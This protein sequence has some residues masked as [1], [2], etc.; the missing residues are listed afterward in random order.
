[1]TSFNPFVNWGA[2]PK[3]SAD[4]QF[5]FKFFEK[6]ADFHFE[7]GDITSV[8]ATPGSPL[9]SNSPKNVETAEFEFV[10]AISLSTAIASTVLFALFF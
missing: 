2:D 4:D 6:G 7:V 8:W 9:A 10:A 1:M 5:V 3:T